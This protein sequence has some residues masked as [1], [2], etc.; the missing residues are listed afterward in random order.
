MKRKQKH[1][2]ERYTGDV[3]IKNQTSALTITVLSVT[4]KSRGTRPALE[5]IRVALRSASHIV[6]AGLISACVKYFSLAECPF[7]LLAAVTTNYTERS[8]TVTNKLREVALSIV[9]TLTHVDNDC[10]NGRG[11]LSV[12]GYELQSDIRCIDRR[13]FK[14]TC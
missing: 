14:V 12:C 5:S 3:W 8:S 10:E 1:N 7:I 11:I 9:L 2:N 6:I 4:R 13:P